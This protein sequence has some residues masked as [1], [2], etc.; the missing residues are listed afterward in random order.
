MPGSSSFVWFFLFVVVG[1]VFLPEH[2]APVILLYPFVNG[3]VL[4][5][6]ESLANKISKHVC[7]ANMHK[8]IGKEAGLSLQSGLYQLVSDITVF[9]WNRFPQGC[10]LLGDGETL[11]G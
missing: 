6:Q 10:V 8:N 9:S 7:Y 1:W 11:T 5:W 4:L 2:K 3:T